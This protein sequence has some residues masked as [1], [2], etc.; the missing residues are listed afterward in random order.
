MSDVSTA[1][2]RIPCRGCGGTGRLI[3]FEGTQTCV[4]CRGSGV[5]VLPPDPI[6]C[7]QCG[8]QG[9]TFTFGQVEREN[10]NGA[11]ECDWAVSP[12]FP[13]SECR[14]AGSIRRPTRW[15]R[16]SRFVW[17]Y[18]AEA[19]GITGLLIGVAVVAY[20]LQLVLPLRVVALL[21]LAV[22]FAPLAL[23]FWVRDRGQFQT[24]ENWPRRPFCTT[25]SSPRRGEG[26]RG[27]RL[28]LKAD[29]CDW[30]R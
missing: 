23:L 21:G 30:V 4:A 29:E 13:C 7:P 26:C 10:L 19:I 14:G 22:V 18:Y 5:Q 8:G 28:R 15:E 11:I 25:A 16:L 9:I 1:E 6:A 17:R 2:R 27:T 24:R 12:Y 3:D 20:A